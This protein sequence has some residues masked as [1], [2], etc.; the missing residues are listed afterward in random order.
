MTAPPHDLANC[1]DGGVRDRKAS[2][3]T[4]SFVFE[5]GGWGN[6]TGNTVDRLGKRSFVFSAIW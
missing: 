6:I 2:N 1:E 4:D 3:D 5:K